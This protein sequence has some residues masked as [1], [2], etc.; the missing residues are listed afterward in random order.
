ML[1]NNDIQ[2]LKEVFATK[3]DLKG[4]ATKDD[5]E[6]LKVKI[7]AIEYSLIQLNDK[8]DRIDKRDYEDSTAFASTLTNH[9][10]RIRRLEQI[11]KREYTQKA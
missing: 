3:D 11:A 7:N 6:Y 10:A 1:T 5:F 4:F 2:R 9:D 8:V